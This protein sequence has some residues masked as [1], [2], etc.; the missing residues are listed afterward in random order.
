M[1]EKL[2]IVLWFCS[3]S[4]NFLVRPMKV[5]GDH[6]RVCAHLLVLTFHAAVLPVEIL[7]ELLVDVLFDEDDQVLSCDL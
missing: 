3:N 7:G 6:A 2:S 5:F 4:V 1:S